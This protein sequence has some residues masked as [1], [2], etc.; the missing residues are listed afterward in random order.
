M[1]IMVDVSARTWIDDRRAAARTNEC[2]HR[3][4]VALQSAVALQLS[5][6]ISSTVAAHIMDILLF[7]KWQEAIVPAGRLL[8]SRAK[9]RIPRPL[10]SPTARRKESVGVMVIK[11]S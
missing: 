6:R 7:N 11:H 1:G 3:Y 2:C 5:Y 10:P 9:V 8:F 4:L